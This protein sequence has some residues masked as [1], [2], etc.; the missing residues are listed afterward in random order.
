M[1][2][3]SILLLLH[4]LKGKV[5]GTHDAFTRSDALWDIHINMWL[6]GKQHADVC[7]DA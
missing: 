2:E 3:K 7:L 1:W 6:G 5:S 4:S